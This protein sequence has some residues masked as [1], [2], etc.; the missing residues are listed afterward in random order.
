MRAG[1]LEPVE[2]RLAVALGGMI[3]LRMLGL[4]LILPVF[5]VMAREVPGFSP[6][7]GGIAVGAYGLTQAL[8]QQPFGWLSDR[9]GR[10]PVLMLG[11]AVFAIGGVVAASAVS[12]QGLILGRALQG[13]GAIAGVAMAFAADGSRPEKRPLMMAAIGM[14][15]GAAFLLSMML[16]VP[17]AN[18]LG[19][20]GLFWLTAAMGGF[21]MLLVLLTPRHIDS[22]AVAA[23]TTVS[24]MKPVWLLALSAFVLHAVMTLVFVVLPGRLI[25]AHDLALAEHWK[26]YVPTMIA[27]VV[28]M[29]PLLARIGAK[30]S[31]STVLSAAFAVIGIA[32]VV[33]SADTRMPALAV[34]V[35]LYFLG[36]NLLEASMPSLLSR[37][38]GSRARGRK[39]GLFSTFQFLGAFV[40]GTVGGL[41][42]AYLGA[43]AALEWAGAACVLWAIVTGLLSRR[44]FRTSAAVGLC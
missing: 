11:L 5:M 30:K 9:W 26:L 34:T 3:S 1:G 38:T 31:E 32:L 10:R 43:A 44:L 4:F 36:F 20:Q 42:L 40:G 19:L 14:G 28:L 41:M 2:L 17:L 23:N 39:M 15:I 27:S 18:V 7:L 12:M 25:V 6:Q 8:M 35:T 37:V 22:H 29:L 13:C 33:L 21:G 16:S 24:S